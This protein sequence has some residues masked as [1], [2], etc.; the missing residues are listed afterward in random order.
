MAKVLEQS[1]SVTALGVVAPPPI[2]VQTPAFEGT[3]ATLFRCVREHK[4]DLMEIPLEPICEAYLLYLIDN[5]ET[6]LDEAAAAL[7]VLAYLLERKAWQLLPV[8]PDE[9]PEYEEPAALLDPTIIEY[10]DVIQMLHSGHEERSKLFF[11]T[12][13]PDAGQYEIPF[14]IGEVTAGDL[15]RAFERLLKRATPEPV[16]LLSKPRKSI[17]EQMKV[18]LMTL[19]SEFQTIDQLFVGGYSRNDAV[20]WFLALLELIRLHRA[21]VRLEGE[22]V[23]FAKK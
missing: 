22:E 18:V 12:S 9:E 21:Q 17:Q 20:Y 6:N 3:L 23:Q 14:S 8:E 15:A 11:R 19:K 13:A 7:T 10:A 16:E 1:A 4:V 2:L 5:A